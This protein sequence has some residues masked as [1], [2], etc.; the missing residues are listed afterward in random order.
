MHPVDHYHCITLCID[1]DI[2]I[3]ANV[4]IISTT[5]TISAAA[6]GSASG[7]PVT[8]PIACV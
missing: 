7:L 8:Y 1:I 3:V 6:A 2:V 4:D 5:G